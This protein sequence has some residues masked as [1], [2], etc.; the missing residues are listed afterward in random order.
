MATLNEKYFA[1]YFVIFMKNMNILLKTNYIKKFDWLCEGKHCFQYIRFD[2]LLS[3]N[4]LEISAYKYVLG[5]P[6]SSCQFW[7]KIETQKI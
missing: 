3:F 2:F 1:Q 4:S 7:K 5:C 6:E